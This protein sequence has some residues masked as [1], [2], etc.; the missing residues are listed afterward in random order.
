MFSEADRLD[1]ELLRHVQYVSINVLPNIFAWVLDGED[2]NKK[3]TFRFVMRF[4]LVLKA[5]LRKKRR[6]KLS[7]LK[8]LMDETMKVFKGGI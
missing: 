6:W 1:Q 5:Y 2:L 4:M 7:E 3:Q 8:T